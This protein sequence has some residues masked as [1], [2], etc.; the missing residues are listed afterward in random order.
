MGTC[1]DQ[2]LGHLLRSES[3]PA[4]C[5]CPP[6]HQIHAIEH[7]E[8]PP[9]PPVQ[10]H[11]PHHGQHPH[12]E[13]CLWRG[14]GAVGQVLGRPDRAIAGELQDQPAAGPHA[15]AHRARVWCLEGRGRD[16]QHEVWAGYGCL[17]GHESYA[18]DRMQTQSSERLSSR[19]LKRWPR[20]SS[21]TT[22]RSSSGRPAPA[23]SPT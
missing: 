13:R 2:P 17:G 22:S 19:L 11:C 14:P 4:L 20:S 1:D 12:R 9:A 5:S 3:T 6:S 7:P 16:G 23:H 18:A 21:S 10:L 8:P 15:A